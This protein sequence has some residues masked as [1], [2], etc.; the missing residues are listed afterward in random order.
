LLA[1]TLATTIA[2][3]AILDDC[4]ELLIVDAIGANSPLTSRT[5]IGAALCRQGGRHADQQYKTEKK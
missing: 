3:V 5:Q 1:A 4:A 2:G